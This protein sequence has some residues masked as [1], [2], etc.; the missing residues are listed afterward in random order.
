MRVLTQVS[1]VNSAGE[2]ET[3]KP[4]QASEGVA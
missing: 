1:A 4:P 3:Y 2:A